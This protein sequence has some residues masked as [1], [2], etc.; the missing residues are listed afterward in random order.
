LALDALSLEALR[1]P[2]L[3][4]SPIWQSPQLK[5]IYPSLLNKV[6][7]RYQELLKEHSKTEP[8]SDLL[9]RARAGM[10]WWQGKFAAAKQDL[11]ALN[12]KDPL[13]THPTLTYLLYES[14]PTLFGSQPVNLTQLDGNDATQL[15]TVA[16]K[17][18]PIQL[19]SHAFRFPQ[20]RSEALRQAWL[21]GLRTAL[22]PELEKELVAGITKS[23]S[24]EQWLKQN[25]PLRQYRRSRTGFGVLSRHIDGPAPDDFA[26][27]TENLLVTGFLSEVFP[28]PR[29]QPELDKAL[30]GWRDALIKTVQELQPKPGTPEPSA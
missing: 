26:V 12:P 2:T 1:D 30:Q 11:D 4:A 10:S 8:L 7:N 25:A 19:L 5:L 18:P 29:Y 16:D 23:S 20:V 21:K 6:S 17:V 28:S 9:R 15:S 14:Q 3:V 22:A 13:A 27:V 24:F